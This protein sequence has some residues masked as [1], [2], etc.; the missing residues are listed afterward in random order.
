MQIKLIHSMR[1]GNADHTAV[2]VMQ[3]ILLLV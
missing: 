2:G 3:T 1:W